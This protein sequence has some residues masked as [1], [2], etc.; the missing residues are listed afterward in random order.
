MNDGSKSL[1]LHIELDHQGDYLPKGKQDPL[2]DKK[3][4]L[5]IKLIDLTLSRGY[6]S[7]I[8]IIDPGYGHNTSLLLKRENRN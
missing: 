5:G 2:F 8:I 4:E 3:P 7:G 6:Q 1:P